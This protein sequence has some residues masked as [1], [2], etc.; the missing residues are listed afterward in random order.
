MAK[1]PN[2]YESVIEHV[3]FAHH[4]AGATSVS[5]SRDDFVSAAKKLRVDLP[6]NL[7]DIIYSFRYRAKLPDKVIKA[8]P[9]SKSWIIMPAGIARYKFVAV[10]SDRFV[11]SHSMMRTSIPDATPGIVAQYAMS[12]EQALLARLRYNRLLDIF[13]GLTCYSLQSHLRTTVPEMGQL[14]VDE[15][16][17]GL[18]RFGSHTVI[19]VQAKG[20]S[21][22]LGLVQVLQD[23][24]MCR[25]KFPALLC[26]AVGAQFLDATTIALFEFA[27]TKDGPRV[28]QERHYRLV[29][30]S[31]ISAEE[32]AQYRQL[33]QPSVR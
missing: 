7:G 5:F 25:I 9:Q 8:A 1:R 18:D 28:V 12:D 11:P 27:E 21:D 14:E 20:G 30:P 10:E 33:A 24:E 31:Q 3:F 6:K 13:T 2:R 19:P 26:R 4:K 29:H 32:L 23:M 22:A 15:L 16:Y 17:V